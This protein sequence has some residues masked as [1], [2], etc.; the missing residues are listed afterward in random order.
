MKNLT[1]SIFNGAPDC[2]ISAAVDSDGTAFLYTA[3]KRDLSTA[4][5]IDD[6]NGVWAVTL[7]HYGWIVVGKYDATNWQNSAI[8]R[9]VA[10]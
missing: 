9:D 1:Q 4:T 6:K 5:D 2:F 7:P 8:N 10:K 3:P